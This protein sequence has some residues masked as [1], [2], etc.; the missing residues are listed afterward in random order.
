MTPKYQKGEKFVHVSD[1]LLMWQVLDIVKH[2]STFSKKT[3]YSVT[4]KAIS[5]PSYI[6]HVPIH[7]FEKHFIKIESGLAETVN[8]LNLLLSLNSQ[9]R[10]LDLP[11]I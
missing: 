5:S 1:R 9:E 7:E 2:S 6:R 3:T 4:L 8:K 10:D 11:K